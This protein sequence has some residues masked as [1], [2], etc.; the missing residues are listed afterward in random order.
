MAWD[1]TMTTMLRSVIGDIT[2]PYTYSDNQL[3][4]LLVVNA[5]L[6]RTEMTFDNSYTID[7]PN[8][9]ISP[10]PTTTD[11]VDDLY[12]NFVVLKSA[13]ILVSAE[14]RVQAKIGISIS[15]GP[16]KIDVGG[17]ANSLAN[18]AKD[19]VNAYERAKIVYMAGNSIGAK[20]VMTPY[21]NTGFGYDSPDVFFN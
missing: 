8:S 1:T 17:S 12:M 18:R 19:M 4:N 21:T 2:S 20:A 15:D 9:G 13:A 10:D 6:I 3:K 11:P 14:A 7:I 16:A 5:Q